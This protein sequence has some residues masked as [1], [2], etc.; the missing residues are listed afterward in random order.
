MAAGAILTKSLFSSLKKKWVRQNCI[1]VKSKKADKSVSF[2]SL[3]N[4]PLHWI[5]IVLVCVCVCVCVCVYVCV[6]V[7]VSSH[8]HHGEVL[9][10]IVMT[11]QA[12]D[13]HVVSQNT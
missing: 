2:T 13:S 9:L 11:T 4:I 12:I 7:C 1:C 3:K 6:F 8:G 5:K 10:K